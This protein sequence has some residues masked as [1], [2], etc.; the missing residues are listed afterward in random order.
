MPSELDTDRIYQLAIKQSETNANLVNVQHD[1]N[2][3]GN[4]QRQNVIDF[5]SA[6]AIIENKVEAIKTDLKIYKALVGLTGG[7]IL[8]LV[9]VFSWLIDHLD[10]IKGLYK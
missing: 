1:I 6:F 9:A 7:I 3:I 5:K 4:A 2:A 10:N 8:I